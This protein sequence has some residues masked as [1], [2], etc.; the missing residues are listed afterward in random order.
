MAKRRSTRKKSDA[1]LPPRS[2]EQL[3]RDLHHLI[4]QQSFESPEEVEA[5]MQEFVAKGTPIP[6]YTPETDQERAQDLIYQA[7]EARTPQKALDLV[8]EALMLDPDC[9]DAYVLM[10]DLTAATPAEAWAFYEAGV[11]AGERALGPE[12]FK[13]NK[14]HFWGILETRPYMRARL[15]LAMVLWDLE[16]QEET[17]QHMAAMLELNPNDNLGVRMLYITLLL[18]MRDDKR[19]NQLLKQYPDDWSAPWLYGKALYEFRKSGAGAKADT[20]LN[21]AMER[22]PHIPL[23]ML[24]KKKLPK[25]PP[26]VDYYSPGDEN[27]ALDYIMQGIRVWVETEGALEW[28]AEVHAR[29]K[30][31][32]KSA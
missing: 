29:S 27:E 32:G 8:R 17:A 4:A 28:M 6:E 30:G 11:K 14:G 3:M 26:M 16:R 19:L 12:F 13:E 15:G 24:D 10:A 1:P 2:H 7:Q 5:F 25:N 18:E 22:N 9:A 20:L 31:Q 21:E 23:F